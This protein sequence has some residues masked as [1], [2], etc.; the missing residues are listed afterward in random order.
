MAL[1]LDLPPSPALPFL[2]WGLTLHI[3]FLGAITVS[4]LHLTTNVQCMREPAPHLLPPAPHSRQISAHA[5]IQCVGILAGSGALYGCKRAVIL[6][7]YFLEWRVPSKRVPFPLP[8]VG[9]GRPSGLR[10]LKVFTVKF[11][12]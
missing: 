3:D 7:D 4:V 2:Q 1:P 10:L 6:T 8:C 5:D 12:K 9:V 11:V